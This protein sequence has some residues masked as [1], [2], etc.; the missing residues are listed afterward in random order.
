M[1]TTRRRTTTT[2]EWPGRAQGRTEV[3]PRL[4]LRLTRSASASSTSSP[5]RKALRRDRAGRLGRRTLNQHAFDMLSDD[6]SDD[7]AEAVSTN[8]VGVNGAS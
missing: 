5:P 8:G 2:G 1:T 3:A 6:F 7:E 4:R